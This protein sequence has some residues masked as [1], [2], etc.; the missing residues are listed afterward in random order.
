MCTKLLMSYKLQMCYKLQMTY[1]EGH[2][3]HLSAWGATWINSL[4]GR[5]ISRPCRI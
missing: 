1:V 2:M 4:Y 3:S 5:T